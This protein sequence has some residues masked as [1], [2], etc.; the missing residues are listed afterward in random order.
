[1]RK[2]KHSELKVLSMLPLGIITLL[3]NGIPD[4]H[5]TVAIIS[6]YSFVIYYKITNSSGSRQYFN[7]LTLTSVILIL[8]KFQITNL[9]KSLIIIF[10][11]NFLSLYS[12]R[13][14]SNKAN[15]DILLPSVGLLLF[16]VA[17][18]ILYEKK[19]WLLQFLGFGYDNAFHLTMFRGYRHDNWFPTESNLEWWTDFGLFRA[20]P[21][22]SSALF[23]I[24]SNLAIGSKHEPYLE[25]ASF[26]VINFG[27]LILLISIFIKL[28]T[29]STPNALQKKN[30]L[31]IS[32]G[33]VGVTLLSTG[34][35]LVNGFPPYALSTL[36]IAYW[37]GMQKFLESTRTKLLNV[38]CL[39]FCV[40]LITPGP[41][42]FL[43]LPAIYLG[44]KAVL[45]AVNR[46]DWKEFSKTTIPVIALAFL[47]L[48]AFNA[49]SGTFG[50]RQI[51]APGGVYRPSLFICILV[52]VIY[53]L[54]LIFGKA[55]FNLFFLTALSGALSLALAS[56]L[57]VIMTGSIQY[58]AIKQLYVWL[59]ICC[60]FVFQY[61]NGKE[62]SKDRYFFKTVS[63]LLA[64]SL[65]ITNIR[66]GKSDS[67][68]MGTPLSA[69]KQLYSQESWKQSIVNAKNYIP[70]E[71]EMTSFT[72]RC[73]IFRMNIYESDLNSRW[74][75]SLTSPLKMGENCFAGYWKSS[76]LNYP[77]LFNHL[78]GLNEEFLIVIPLAFQEEVS[79]ISLP[80]NTEIIYR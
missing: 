8:F 43:F 77:G 64:L 10:V 75:N 51:L 68:Y 17:T 25:M 33:V 55:P 32:V 29:N 37:L 5:Q 60:I 58:Y 34:V 3:I 66:S 47:S 49:T 7:I 48:S 67:G 20:A 52:T 53:V 13:L 1:M 70:N 79:K 71:F 56:I 74:A 2:L 14:N 6:F 35:L 4:L 38:S 22:G 24:V 72:E 23:S 31:I 36:L 26:G 18:N 9:E 21:A 57:T 45:E 50:W 44:S 39:I 46:R 42:A 27:M 15:F 78:Q 11:F 59:P 65:V 76:D 41:A 63:V 69:M 40:L 16:I 61:L 19:V 54:I 30:S 73:I 12:Y 28:A 62:F 80:N